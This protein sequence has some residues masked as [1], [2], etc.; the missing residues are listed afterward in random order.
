MNYLHLVQVIAQLVVSPSL[1]LVE[2]PTKLTRFTCQQR[3]RLWSHNSDFYDIS[4]SYAST[5]RYQTSTPQ[6]MS[7]RS[8][9]NLGEASQH[10]LIGQSWTGH[11]LGL[12][13]IPSKR[14]NN[15]QQL[16]LFLFV[17]EKPLMRSSTFNLAPSVSS[18]KMTVTMKALPAF[19]FT[20]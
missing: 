16:G 2:I 12:G 19:F 7:L 1:F 18:I 8:S 14:T 5:P 9:R 17:V 4:D 13:L 6:T 10:D 11:K 3:W 20:Q 15:Y